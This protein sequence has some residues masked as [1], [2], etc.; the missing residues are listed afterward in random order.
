MKIA[1]LA[2]ALAATIL[3]LCLLV[4]MVVYGIVKQFPAF[5]AAISLSV[6]GT[7]TTVAVR[8][9]DYVYLRAFWIIEALY[10]VLAFLALLEIFKSVF[11]GFYHIPWFRFLFPAI[12]VVMVC[13]AV[14]RSLLKPPAQASRA[15]TVIIFMEL[16]VRFLQIGILFLFFALVQFFHMRWKQ[17][18]FGIALGFGISAAGFLVVFLLRSEF[19]TKLDYVVRIAPPIA[20][21]L[22]VVVW[23]LTFIAPEQD[24]PLQGPPPAL[25]PEEMLAEVRQYSSTVKKILKR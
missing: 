5:F 8:N 18:P 6:I 13:T 9:N 7:I 20:Y 16:A 21:T 2:L 25:T 22:A 15:F 12:G 10:V 1:E 23:L 4:Y 17:R 24:H 3:Q 19:G 11:A 14:I